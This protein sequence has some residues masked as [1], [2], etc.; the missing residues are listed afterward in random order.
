MLVLAGL[1]VT[2]EMVFSRIVLEL[3]LPFWNIT[4]VGCVVAG[5]VFAGAAYMRSYPPGRSQ[6]KWISLRCIFGTVYWV[7]SIAAVQIGASP[8]DVAALTSINLVTAAFMGRLFLKERVHWVHFVALLFSIAGA[9]LVCQPV[10]LFGGKSDDDASSA[11]V[12]GYVLAI[13]SGFMQGCF[14]ISCRKCAG[15]S[16]WTPAAA[17]ITSTVFCALLPYT[18]LVSEPSLDIVIAEPW[19]AIGFTMIAAATTIVSVGTVSFGSALC[20]AVVS[21]TVYT[22]ASMGSG[23]VAQTVLFSAAPNPLTLIGAALM[24]IAV[25]LMAMAKPVGDQSQELPDILCIPPSE[26]ASEG[27]PVYDM[28][29]TDSFASFCASEYAEF[30][31]QHEPVRMRRHI[32]MSPQILGAMG[33]VTSVVTDA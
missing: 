5:L 19:T 1:A 27:T 16:D 22:A 2:V 21:A 7:C 23:Y 20:P 11:T 17:M 6:A 32:D 14:F 10:F 26:N 9:V 25:I 15:A 24:F 31:L 4:A 8:G 30:K 18:G 33:A 3:E 28:I 12:L 29:E 13:T